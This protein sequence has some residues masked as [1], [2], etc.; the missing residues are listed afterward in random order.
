MTTY[1]S[2]EFGQS[3]MWGKWF[4]TVFALRLHRWWW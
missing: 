2:S 4:S 3:E 1:H